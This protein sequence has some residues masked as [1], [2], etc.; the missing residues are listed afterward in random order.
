MFIT[1]KLG[2]YT[3]HHGYDENNDEITE[4]VKKEGFTEKIVKVDRIL[5]VSESTILITSAYDRVIYWE[6]E[7]EMSII[8]AR[9]R[10]SGFLVE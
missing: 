1:L 7:G 2:N 4:E 10:N 5:S 9:L 6:Y 3:I 8:H